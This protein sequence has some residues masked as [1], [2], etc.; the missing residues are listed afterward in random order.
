MQQMTRRGW[1]LSSLASPFAM[2][3]SAQGLDLR[4]DAHN[5]LHV[6]GLKFLSGKPLQRLKDGATVVF[7]GQLSVSYDGNATIAA[8]A[9][10]RFAMSYDIWEERFSVTRVI[11]TKEETA[12]RIASHLALDPVQSWCLDNLTLDAT[13]IPA[14]RPFWIR[15]EM[16]TEDGRDGAGIVGDPGINL[17]RLVEIFSRPARAPQERW[18]LD[19]GPLRLSEVRK[20]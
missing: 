16:R 8:R 2:A 9:I 12:P 13:V 20:S 6:S 7:L 3:L 17:T 10:A 4:V 1:L 11:V 14:D 5:V 19:S 18:Q 15:V